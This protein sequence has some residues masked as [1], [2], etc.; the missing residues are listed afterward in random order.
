M[1]QV[2]RRVIDRK[3]RIAVLE[4]PEGHLGED[5]VLVENHYSLISSGTELSTLRKTPAELVRQTIAD[6]KLFHDTGNLNGK[7]FNMD[8]YQAPAR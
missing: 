4:L 5:Q 6:P 7:P 8:D 1:R 3:G 2:V